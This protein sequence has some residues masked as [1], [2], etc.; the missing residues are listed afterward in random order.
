M[1]KITVAHFLKQGGYSGAEN[2][3]IQIIEGTSELCDSIYVS[4]G[5]LISNILSAKGIN[6]YEL[7]NISIGCIKKA[8]R[9]IQPDIIH[10]H[11][12]SMSLLLGLSSKSIP[13]ISHLH[14]N[15]PWIKYL[16]IKSIAYY[17]ASR[18]YMRI[19]CVSDSIMKEYVFGRFIH[20]PVKIIGN[21]VDIDAIRKKVEVDSEEKLFN[22]AYLGRFSP[23]KNPIRFIRIIDSIK[24]KIPEINA[25]MI[26]D[27][28]LKK[29]VENEIK[30]RGLESTIILTGFLSNPYSILKQSEILCMTSDWEGYGL[31]AVEALALG[32]PVVCTHVGGLPGIVDSTCG[33]VCESE[34]EILKVIKAI[35]LNNDKM[36]CL[37]EGALKRAE[38]LNNKSCYMRRMKNTYKKLVE[39]KRY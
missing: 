30:S 37:H 22:I 16:N 31:A 38:E 29:E 24:R 10:A 34:D 18:K 28:E 9:S 13:I 7:N 25:I 14:N 26:G 4:P 1:K 39:M 36:I 3:V 5:G 17:L 27:G 6:Y 8:L 23:P 32:V 2:V 12:Y 15:P 35:L 33:K 19:F 21:P 20:V 11:D